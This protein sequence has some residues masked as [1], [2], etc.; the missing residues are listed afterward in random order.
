MA[1]AS[2]PKN[3]PCQLSLGRWFNSMLFTTYTQKVS[4]AGFGQDT[5]LRMDCLP[6]TKKTVKSGW[7]GLRVWRALTS[8]DVLWRRSLMYLT[9]M[10]YRQRYPSR[11]SSP[12]NSSKEVFGN[13]SH[14]SSPSHP[15]ALPNSKDCSLQPGATNVAYAISQKLYSTS[16]IISS[17]RIYSALSM[18]LTF[19]INS[20]FGSK[21]IEDLQRVCYVATHFG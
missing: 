7:H 20:V 13:A 6:V 2:D 4:R 15:L 16:S 9:I 14:A 1:N 5:H 10:C 21:S 8:T 18:I 3:E 12:R 11:E 17:N 19:S